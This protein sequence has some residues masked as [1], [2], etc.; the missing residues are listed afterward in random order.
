V[1]VLSVLSF[2]LFRVTSGR[3]SFLMRCW[4]LS[5]S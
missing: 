3:E 4:L 5:C 2:H 1:S